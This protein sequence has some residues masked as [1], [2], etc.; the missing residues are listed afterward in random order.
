MI[1]VTENGIWMRQGDTGNI[2]FT[3]LPTDKPYTVYLSVYNP[4]EN[5]ILKEIPSNIDLGSEG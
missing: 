4:D 1:R 3:G 2:T 5:I